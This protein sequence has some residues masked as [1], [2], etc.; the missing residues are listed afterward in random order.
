MDGRLQCHPRALFELRQ[1]SSLHRRTVV[2]SLG[3]LVCWFWRL[4]CLTVVVIRGRL[5]SLD[6]HPTASFLHG[7]ST[8]A[9]AQGPLVP[10]RR[11][12]TC[13]AYLC[14]YLGANRAFHKGSTDLEPAWTPLLDA[15]HFR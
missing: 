2:G 15:T 5:R 7:R 12:P 8:P 10:T 1:V 3:S 13:G 4:R 6:R 9:P 11:V 14:A